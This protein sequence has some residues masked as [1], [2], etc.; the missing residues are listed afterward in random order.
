MA[1][2]ARGASAQAIAAAAPADRNVASAS[3]R[4]RAA[5]ARAILRGARARRRRRRIVLSWVLPHVAQ[6]DVAAVPGRFG[7]DGGYGTSGYSD[8]KEDMVAILMTQ[9]VWDSAG[10]PAVYLD[11]WTQAYQA[12]D[13]LACPAILRCL[14]SRQDGWAAGSSLSQLKGQVMPSASS[15]LPAKKISPTHVDPGDPRSS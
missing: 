14:G 6:A 1:D 8:P 12:I 10:I 4:H 11:F 13:D 3:R 7:W 2:D 9:R 15:A 5:W